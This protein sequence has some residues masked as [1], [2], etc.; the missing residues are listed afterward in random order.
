LLESKLFVKR[1]KCEFSQ[2]EIV[3]LGHFI[4]GVGVAMDRRKVPVLDWPPPCSVKAAQVFLGLTG[5][6]R[7]FIKGYGDIAMPL[8]TL[9]RK[10]AFRW[11]QEADATFRALQSAPVL[12][13]PI[14]TEPFIVECDASGVGIGSVLY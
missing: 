12:Q 10:D 5:Y 11:G 3:Y 7:R 8:T 13:L 6:Y 4:S 2:R 14:F 9:L 1:T